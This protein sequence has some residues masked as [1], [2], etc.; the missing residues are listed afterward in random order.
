M[1]AG[2]EAKKDMWRKK[3][4]TMERNEL[5]AAGFVILQGLRVGLEES[6]W[7][8]EILKDEVNK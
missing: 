8:A 4:R 2:I 1:K 6:E 5:I 3:V 7:M